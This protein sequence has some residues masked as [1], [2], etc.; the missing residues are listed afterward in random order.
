MGL[1]N[2]LW[3]RAFTHL[4]GELNRR[5]Y[6][7]NMRDDPT[8]PVPS[9]TQNSLSSKA[10]DS[11]HAG[12]KTLRRQ[13][14][15]TMRVGPSSATRPRFKNATVPPSGFLAVPILLSRFP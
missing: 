2:L 1:W 3:K 6:T 10:S 12:Y 5:G 13:S 4:E 7:T 11:G 14:Q 8:T 9:T 15:P